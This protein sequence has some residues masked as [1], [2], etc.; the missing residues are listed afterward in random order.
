MDV[1]RQQMRASRKQGEARLGMRD[2][3]SVKPKEDFA[4][5]AENVN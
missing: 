4:N 5:D 1:T 3:Y 2:L